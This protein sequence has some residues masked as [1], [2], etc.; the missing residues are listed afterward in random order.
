MIRINLLPFRAARKK[1]NIRRQISIFVLSLLLIFV[2][3]L[4][5][6]FQQSGE[7]KE[8]KA[9]EAQLRKNLASYSEIIKQ[10]NELKK[11]TKDKQVKM[12]V[13]RGLEKLKTGPVHLLDE[14]STAVPKNRLWLR[15][16]AEKQGMLKLKG[17]AKDN[18]TVA[19][20]M[21][22]LEKA[23]HIKSVDLNSARLTGAG[24]D[25]A[26]IQI[27]DFEL[28]CKTYTYKEKAGKRP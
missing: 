8:L 23:E 9:M 5:F 17:T 26:K 4:Y 28:K 14:I 12:E 25:K 24:K 18:D 16:L 6:F 20:F 11:K 7:L 22:N 15:L 19:I 13:I 10:V 3:I 1:E 21:T 2:I 27:T